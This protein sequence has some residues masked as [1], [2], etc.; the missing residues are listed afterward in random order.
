MLGPGH[1]SGYEK[2]GKLP[3]L[4]SEDCVLEQAYM[5]YS[6]T[7]KTSNFKKE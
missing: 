6:I 2:V 3:Q 4:I 7:L 5:L 1:W